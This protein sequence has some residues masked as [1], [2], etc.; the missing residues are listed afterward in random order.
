MLSLLSTTVGPE[1]K[2]F[3]QIGV[4]HL[5]KSK[6]GTQCGAYG[7]WT[8]LFSHQ[9]HHKLHQLIGRQPVN[10]QQ[11]ELAYVSSLPA[12]PKSC[13]KI[14]FF[15]GNKAT[16]CTT[17]L[18]WWTGWHQIFCTPITNI[19]YPYNCVSEEDSAQM[20]SWDIAVSG[21]MIHSIPRGNYESETTFQGGRGR[22]QP[23]PK[24]TGHLD[25][26]VIFDTAC[27]GLQIC[28][29]NFPHTVNICKNIFCGAKG[30]ELLKCQG[31]KLIVMPWPQCWVQPGQTSLLFLPW[32]PSLSWSWGII[33]SHCAKWHQIQM[34]WCYIL[35]L[36][37]A[38]NV[39]CTWFCEDVSVWHHREHSIKGGSWLLLIRGN[40]DLKLLTT[41]CNLSASR[42]FFQVL[43]QFSSTVLSS[44][45]W[46]QVLWYRVLMSSRV[47]KWSLQLNPPVFCCCLYFKFNPTPS[48]R[49][50]P[51]ATINLIIISSQLKCDYL[52]SFDTI[53]GFNSFDVLN[54]NLSNF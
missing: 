13:T 48:C 42:F 40:A 23:I 52:N 28:T 35:H 24:R 34:S 19:V 47:N 26:E 43:L 39:I 16:K 5:W 6:S 14:N 30:P 49:S 3:L 29:E 38:K 46:Y 9:D 37:Y 20:T 1:H 36:C 10:Q 12:N 27:D 17:F 50:I 2:S 11:H 15:S 18:M 7:R 32:P 25:R 51:N 53:Q 8:G 31:H 45:L 33:M 54:N 4:A 22:T 21:K 44:K 41:V